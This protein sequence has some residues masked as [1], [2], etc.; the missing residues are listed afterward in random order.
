MSTI[1]DYL[2]L[3]LQG[4]LTEDFDLFLNL[5]YSSFIYS[6]VCTNV[7]VSLNQTNFQFKVMTTVVQKNEKKMNWLSFF[8]F[9]FYVNKIYSNI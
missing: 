8:F 7:F 5:K 3:K 2:M 4:L 1:C 9:N 6:I